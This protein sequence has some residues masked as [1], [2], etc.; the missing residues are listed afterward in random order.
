MKKAATVLTITAF[1]LTIASSAFASLRHFSGTWT[2]SDPDTRG[3]TA[4]DIDVSDTRVTVQ[5]WGRCHPRD[6]DWGRVEGEVYAPD[7]SSNLRESAQLISAV[8]RSGRG[9]RL[10]L[11]RRGGRNELNV[12]VLVQF[13]DRRGIIPRSFSWF[14]LFENN[15]KSCF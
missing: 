5:A 13:G 2:N 4:L 8:F 11:I 3:I 6:C 14:S 1:F 15:G 9:K 12:E 10:L 7:V